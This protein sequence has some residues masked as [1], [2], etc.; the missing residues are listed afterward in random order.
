MSKNSE[1]E[2]IDMLD[3]D[4]KRYRVGNR[5][6]RKKLLKDEGLP[7]Q[8]VGEMIPPDM[9]PM[10][11][12]YKIGRN[13]PCPCNRN[14]EDA[15]DFQFTLEDGSHPSRGRVLKSKAIKYKD[16]CFQLGEYENYK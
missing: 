7:P 1:S 16:C 12:E 9:M 4:Y 13:D 14:E 11:K 15:I 10:I 6:S 5:R 2:A 8:H 3:A